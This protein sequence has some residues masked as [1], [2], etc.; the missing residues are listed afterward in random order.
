MGGP[1][2]TAFLLQLWSWAVRVRE[3]V[4]PLSPVG[5]QAPMA[6]LGQRL[7]A[8]PAGGKK[9]EECGGTKQESLTLS[10]RVTLKQGSMFTKVLTGLVRWLS[11]GILSTVLRT[12]CM[13]GGET[14]SL[15]AALWR[16]HMYPTIHFFLK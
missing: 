11:H 10:Q 3:K 9:G 6:I 14:G 1:L 7:G 16:P 8:M 13:V 2:P 15:Q 5:L 12:V 4:G